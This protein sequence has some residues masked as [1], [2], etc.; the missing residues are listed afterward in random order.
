MYKKKDLIYKYWK[1]DKTDDGVWKIYY[2]SE[3][4]VA[5]KRLK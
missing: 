1:I 3:S 2:S 4:I 5:I